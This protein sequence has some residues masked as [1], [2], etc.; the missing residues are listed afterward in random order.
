[1][2]TVMSGAPGFVG[3]TD[4][5]KGPRPVKYRLRWGSEKEYKPTPSKDLIAQL[6]EGDVRMVKPDHL[7][8]SFLHAFQVRTGTVDACRMCLLDEKYTLLT[9]DNHVVFGKGEKICL[10]CGIREL[11][12]ELAPLGKIGRGHKPA[13]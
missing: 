9:D 6:R 5:P 8:E 13:F 2:M 11:R 4:T 7:F 12:R 3:L 10:D 1:M